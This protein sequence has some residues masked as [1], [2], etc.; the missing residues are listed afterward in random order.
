MDIGN[1][2]SALWLLDFQPPKFLCDCP[3][4]VV[5]G[6]SMANRPCWALLVAIFGYK[7]EMFDRF[8]LW[9]TLTAATGLNLRYVG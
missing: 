2:F 8:F 7:V 3:I 9:A 4:N 5:S 6:R 1:N